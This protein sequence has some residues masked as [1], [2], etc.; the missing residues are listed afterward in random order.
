MQKIVIHT[1]GGARGNPGP[2]AIG[3]VIAAEGEEVI[4]FG[5]YVGEQTNNW[6]EYEALIRALQTAHEKLGEKFKDADVE[7]RMDSQLVV[8]QIEG[9]YKVKEPTLK[10]K[11]AHATKLLEE[12]APGAHFTHVPREENAAADALVNSTL[13]A[14]LL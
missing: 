7:I 8:R 12:Y 1:D 6:A 4:E 9:T 11:H 3:V 10:E 5:E 14:Q 13:D 2:A